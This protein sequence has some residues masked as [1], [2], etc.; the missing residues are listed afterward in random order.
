MGIIDGKV[1]F[2]VEDQADS[3]NGPILNSGHIAIRCMWK[4]RLRIRNLRVFNREPAYD[5]IQEV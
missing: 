1:I 4:T 2:D 5:V 3:N